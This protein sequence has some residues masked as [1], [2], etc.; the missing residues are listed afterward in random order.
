MGNIRQ[1]IKL[2]LTEL[3]AGLMASLA[4]PRWVDDV[5]R[6]APF[7]S[8]AELLEVASEAATPLSGSEIDEAIAHHPRI[9]EKPVGDGAAQAF[10]RSEQ[11]GLGSDEDDLAAQIAAGNTAYEERFGRVFIIR[12]A[13]R[14]RAEILIELERRLELSN[15]SELEI[16]GE[17]LRDIAL[18]RIEKLWAVPAPTSVSA[19]IS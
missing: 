14:S 1:M 5:V 9:G 10:S 12:A 11:A 18:L 3:R 2:S 4:V 6:V 15:S 17:Q 8:V 19:G 13:G 16:V 7:D